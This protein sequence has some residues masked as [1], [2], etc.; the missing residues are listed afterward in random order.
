MCTPMQDDLVPTKTVAEMLGKPVGTI[1]RWAKEGKLE[2]AFEIP[3][4]TGARL[5]RRSDIEA[6]AAAEAAEAAS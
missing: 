4:R 6:F 2:P 5:Y 1:N 3:G